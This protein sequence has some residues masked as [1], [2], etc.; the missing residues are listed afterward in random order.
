[1]LNKKKCCSTIKLAG[2]YENNLSFGLAR[3]EHS[4]ITIIIIC[5]YESREKETEKKQKKNIFV[6][7]CVNA[8][9]LKQKTFQCK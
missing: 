7:N 3:W 5:T 9:Q 6:C 1:M 8:E 4:V 2:E